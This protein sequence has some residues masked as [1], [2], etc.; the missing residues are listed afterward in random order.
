[1]KNNEALFVYGYAPLNNLQNI[2]ENALTFE[3]FDLY[4]LCFFLRVFDF[5]LF[6][7]KNFIF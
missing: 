7:S 3:L 2:N 5:M 1:M 6:S 4:L